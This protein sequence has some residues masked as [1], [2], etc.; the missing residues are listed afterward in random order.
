MVNEI[1]L[2]NDFLC[3]G[4]YFSIL[5]RFGQASYPF[6]IQ[7]RKK[8]TSGLALV[9]PFADRTLQVTRVLKSERENL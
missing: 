4:T 8:R 1:G 2:A 7:F 9:I 3:D 6:R 5:G